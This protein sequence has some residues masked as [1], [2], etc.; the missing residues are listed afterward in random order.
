MMLIGDT[1]LMR[2]TFLVEPCEGDING[3][4][5]VD[6]SDLASHIAGQTGIC[7]EI[8]AEAFSRTNCPL[9][10]LYRKT[11]TQDKG[12]IS[13]LRITCDARKAPSRCVK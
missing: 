1:A 13:M 6:G 4:G 7:I 2:N 3:D 10:R 9:K 5:D 12:I 8:F 11:K